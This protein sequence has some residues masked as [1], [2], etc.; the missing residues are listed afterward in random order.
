MSTQTPS[1]A[2]NGSALSGGQKA[3]FP[4]FNLEDCVALPEAL[5]RNGGQPLPPVDL[6]IAIGRSPGG[7][8]WRQLTASSSQYGLTKGSYK[9]ML[10]ELD[11][12]GRA[13]TSPKSAVERATALVGAA[14]NPAVF[15]TAFDY[16]KG[17]K[18]PERQF[19]MNTAER[20]FGV[21]PGQSAQFV[22]IFTENV[23]FVGLMR[24]TPGGE[25]LANEPVA[26]PSGVAARDEMDVDV[27]EPPASSDGLPSKWPPSTPPT[28]EP[29]RK[30]R[31]NRMLLCHGGN[32]KPLQQLKAMLDQLGIPYM[33]AKTEPNLNRPISAKVRETMDQCGA[34]ILIFS[35]DRQFFGRDGESVWLSS[36]NV[37]NELGATSVLYDDRVIVF[38]DDSVQLA[39][40]YSGVGYIP[41][42]TDKLDAKMPDLLRELLAMKILKMEVND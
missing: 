30:D 9:A 12:Y 26:T 22:D 4:K 11:E 7:S 14:L 42:E 35:P 20:E 29:G 24:D 40:N 17:K 37:A 34:A 18:F 25:W 10:I 1:R 39:S 38:K 5:G 36:E 13:V 23:R 21:T 15:R 28:G 31:P 16:Y 19:F 41:F 3:G 27:A 8:P 2:T 33:V 6:A 32:D